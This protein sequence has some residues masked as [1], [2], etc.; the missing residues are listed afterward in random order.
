[1]LYTDITNCDKPQSLASVKTYSSDQMNYYLPLIIDLSVD[2]LLV[3]IMY[4]K[5]VC[6]VKHNLISLI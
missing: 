5:E 3:L 1:M 4:I 2:F 6:F